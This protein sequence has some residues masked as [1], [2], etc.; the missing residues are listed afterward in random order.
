MSALEQDLAYEAQ[1]V[2]AT[3]E[4]WLHRYGTTLGCALLVMA[5]L[6]LYAA[7]ATATASLTVVAITTRGD[8]FVIPNYDT[9]QEAQAAAASAM[10]IKR[11]VASK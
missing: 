11:G 10:S 8:T 9:P 5:S 7:I 3:I 1:D 2:R 4:G 6:S